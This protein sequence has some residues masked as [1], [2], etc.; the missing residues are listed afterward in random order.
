MF[1][2]MD[3]QFN[4]YMYS[5]YN[6]VGYINYDVTIFFFE[7]MYFY[8]V[9]YQFFAFFAQNNIKDKKKCNV[10][11]KHIL[12]IIWYIE[13]SFLFLKTKCLWNMLLLVLCVV[14]LRR[15]QLLLS[16]GNCTDI[17]YNGTS[18]Y[19]QLLCL[20]TS[21]CMT[22]SPVKLSRPVFLFLTFFRWTQFFYMKSWHSSR[23][24]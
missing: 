3:Y 21:L 12:T 5:Y 23:A 14:F 15:I 22:Q 10:I 18:R 11:Y 24:F 6:S 2:S 19:C 1:V 17:E 7:N 4:S 8:Y 13:K 20:L 9:R 16:I